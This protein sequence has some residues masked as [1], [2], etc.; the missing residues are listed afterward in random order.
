MS[1]FEDEVFLFLNLCCICSLKK[2]QLHPGT[3]A[4]PG[5]KDTNTM[6]TAHP[7]GCS[8]L[9]AAQRTVYNFL[10]WLG[11]KR[12]DVPRLIVRAWTDNRISNTQV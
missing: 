3:L 10:S 8:G 1:I 9:L 5:G 7:A 11:Y 12:Y 4:L 6:N 2:R